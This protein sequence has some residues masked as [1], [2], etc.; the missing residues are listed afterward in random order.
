MTTLKKHKA[1][2]VIPT[3]NGDIL[4]E[5]LEAISKQQTPWDFECL[6]IDSGIKDQT[7]KIAKIF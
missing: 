6:I 5:V 1:S 4:R 2:I 3:Y 7:L